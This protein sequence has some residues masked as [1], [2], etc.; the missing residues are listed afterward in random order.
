MKANLQTAPTLA[1]LP[2]TKVDIEAEKQ[3]VQEL[4]RSLR[5]A[6]NSFIKELE[7]FLSEQ[8][9]H[10][11]RRKQ[12]LHKRWTENVWLPCWRRL[13]ERE[14][15]CRPQQNRLRQALYDD[16]LRHCNS[17]QFVFLEAYDLREYNPFLLN[18]RKP[19]HF[20]MFSSRLDTIPDYIRATA[21][22]DGRCHQS[23]CWCT[24]TLSGLQPNQ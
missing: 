22:S 24:E 10:K 23:S 21:T 20:K 2:E 8:D 15:S 17:K 19:Q 9:D 1:C 7:C 3:K 4:I 5:D 6:E 12:L 16:Y 14:G 11:L 18:T 13:E